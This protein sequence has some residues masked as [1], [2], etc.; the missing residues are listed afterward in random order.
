VSKAGKGAASGRPLPVI[1]GGASI[2]VMSDHDASVSKDALATLVENQRT[3]L[4]FLE[5]RVGDRATA[6]DL[7]QEAFARA[8]TAIEGLRDEESAVAWFY[9]MLRNA[10]IDHYRRTGRS[11]RAL[12]AFARELDEVVPSTEVHDQV[13]A[14]IGRLAST[15]KPEYAEVLRD[16]EV[17]GQPLKDYAESHGI[18]TNN[19]T[20]RVHRARQAL[21]K[22]VAAAC[23]VCAVHGCVDCR[24]RPD[25][26]A[27][28]AT[29]GH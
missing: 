15:L 3:F 22:Q 14:C 16:V 5:K 27:L 7:L 25:P 9:R 1:P 17:A 18:T 28:T 2:R 11:R 29:D 6:E 19:A 21:R 26:P 24:C 8:V 12:E 4:R 20:V 23:G 13:C 10:V